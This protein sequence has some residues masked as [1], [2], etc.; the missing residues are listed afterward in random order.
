VLGNDLHRLDCELLLAVPGEHGY[1][2]VADDIKLRLISRGNLDEDIG[3]VQR[4]FRVISVNDGRKRAHD[5]I[6]VE[7]DGV[8]RLV[9]NDVEVAP[10]MLVRLVECHHFFAVHLLRLVQGREVDI[11]WWQSLIRERSL[12]CVEIM[13]ADPAQSQSEDCI[14]AFPGSSNY[15]RHEGSLSCQVLVKLI[16]QADEG[17]ICCLGKLEVPEDRAGDVRSDF[18]RLLCHGD[19][20]HLALWDIQELVLWCRMLSAEDV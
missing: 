13:G 19:A 11:L 1:H 3:G 7:D 4:Y 12:D 2:D 6:G 15:S 8:D 16:L 5:L 17:L 18:G 9:P 20:L 10:E 14:Y